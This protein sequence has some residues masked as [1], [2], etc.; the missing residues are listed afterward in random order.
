MGGFLK[1]VNKEVD[2]EMEQALIL[3]LMESINARY[4]HPLAQ[5]CFR[6]VE[7]ALPDFSIHSGI[8][9]NNFE[10]VANCP[11]S[12]SAWPELWRSTI[13][14]TVGGGFHSLEQL[15]AYLYE[16][17]KKLIFLVDGLEDLVTRE[18]FPLIL[19]SL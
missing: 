19:L 11:D 10:M 15:D 7:E 1:I 13:L 12:D 8:T 16:K 3:P 2:S 18:L 4:L 17:G 6:K 14:Q 9:G 5:K